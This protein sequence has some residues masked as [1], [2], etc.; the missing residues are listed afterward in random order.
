MSETVYLHYTQAELDR[1]YNQRVWAQNADELLERWRQT[2]GEV[3]A[4]HPGYEEIAYGSGANERLD[5]YRTSAT[6][7]PIH[8]HVHGGAWRFQTKDDGALVARAMTEAGM[9]FVVPEFDKLPDVRMPTMVE[10]LVRVVQWAYRNADAFG[11]DR[12]RILLSGHSSGA[13]LAAVLATLDWTRHDLPA[14][15]LSSLVCISGAYDL[16]AVMLSA[17]RTYIDLSADEV[18]LLSAPRHVSGIRCPVWVLY[19]DGET[20]EFIRQAH[21][22][23]ETLSTCGKLKALTEVAGCNHFEIYERMSDPTGPVFQAVTEAT[24]ASE[25]AD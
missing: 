4:T 22:F 17:R 5:L 24:R 12:D 13:H 6:P 10:Q 18:D 11:G 19:G 7:A 15:V 8:I 21:A 14:D 23:A 1:A 25:T 2:A 16:E 20:P 9:H 3:Q